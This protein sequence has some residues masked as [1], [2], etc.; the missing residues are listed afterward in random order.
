[1][2]GGV[3]CVGWVVEEAGVVFG[4]VDAVVAA[5]VGGVVTGGGVVMAGVVS[6]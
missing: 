4:G 5:V 3:V 1:M 2:A 6:G